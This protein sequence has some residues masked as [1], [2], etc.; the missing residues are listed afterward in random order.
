MHIPF[1]PALMEFGSPLP[2]LTLAHS[3]ETL[4]ASVPAL[5]GTL[6]Q[7]ELLR[8]PQS[9]DLDAVTQLV[10]S[11]LGLCLQVLRASRWETGGDELWRISDCVVNLGPRVLEVATPLQRDETRKH[12][13]K[14]AEAFWSHARLVASISE[15]VATYCSELGVNPEQAYTAGLLHNLRE[16]PEILRPVAEDACH[17]ESEGW[18]HSCH[19]PSFVEEVVNSVHAVREP[20]EMSPLVRV[21]SFACKW[22][23]L[24]LPWPECGVAGRSRFAL[25]RTQIESLIADYFSTVSGSRAQQLISLLSDVTLDNLAEESPAHVIRNKRRSVVRME[26]RRIAGD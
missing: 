5:P 6:V 3:P 11:D 1:Y 15:A 23:E 20:V 9:I 19:L 17:C 24:G 14:E 26:R 22:V 10:R 13:Y 25:P 4:A 8:K 16:L 2:T 21:V 18:I 12:S 7:L